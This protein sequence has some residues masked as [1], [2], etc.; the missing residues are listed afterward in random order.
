MYAFITNKLSKEPTKYISINKAMSILKEK[1]I[2][3]KLLPGYG[4]LELKKGRY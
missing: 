2:L 1:G 4:K 3:I